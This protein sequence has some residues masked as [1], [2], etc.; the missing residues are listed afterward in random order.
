[1]LL[2]ILAVVFLPLGIVF[3][4]VG[5]TA[6]RLDRGE[7]E[8]M[9]VL[10]IVLGAV[11]LALALAFAVLQRRELVQRRRRR[12][13]LRTTAEIVHA[14]LNHNVRS[15]AKVALRITVRFVPAGT[16]SRTVLALPASAP[17]VGARIDVLYDPA[18]PTNFEPVLS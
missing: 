17:A 4:I 18:D 5:A 9:L 13:G 3:T 11:G 16:V 12:E 2:G 15:G 6:E 7:P 10:G 14:Q 1:M 8:S